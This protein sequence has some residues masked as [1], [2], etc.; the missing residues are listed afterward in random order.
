VQ[1]G[2]RT[3]GNPADPPRT[4]RL[5]DGFLHRLLGDIEVADGPLQGRD[6]S[7]VLLAYDPG[8]DGVRSLA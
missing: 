7:D 6:Q 5:H 2:S 4:Q 8:Q 3:V 1:P